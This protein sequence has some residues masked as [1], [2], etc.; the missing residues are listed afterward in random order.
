VLSPSPSE[1]SGPRLAMIDLATG[2]IRFL[3]WTV[4]PGE[5]AIFAW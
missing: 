3:P 1:H 5:L 4:L 2:S